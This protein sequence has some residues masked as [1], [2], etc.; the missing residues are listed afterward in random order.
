MFG[1]SMDNVRLMR[2][3]CEGHKNHGIRKPSLKNPFMRLLL[4]YLPFFRHRF[5]KAI[6]RERSVYN[7]E[8]KKGN[9]RYR[10]N[11]NVS[12]QRPSLT[13]E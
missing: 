10:T 5:K 1:S 4:F 11:D 3:S 9:S 12:V 6:L 2:G 13:K 8:C 7:F